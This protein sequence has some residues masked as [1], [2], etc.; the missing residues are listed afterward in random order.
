MFALTW[1]FWVWP[2]LHFPRTGMTEVL[3]G[4]HTSVT[5]IHTPQSYFTPR[6]TRSHT[7]QSPSRHC[8]CLLCFQLPYFLCFSFQLPPPPPHPQH[9]NHGAESHRSANLDNLPSSFSYPNIRCIFVFNICMSGKEVV[10]C[11][12]N[13]ITTNTSAAVQEKAC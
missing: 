3:F 10:I 9:C 1:K 2:L 11:K 13:K 7:P 4:E 8:T 12:R 6:Q 5:N